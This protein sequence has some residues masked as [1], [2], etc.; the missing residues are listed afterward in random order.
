[1][2]EGI[3]E[4]N[5]GSLTIDAEGPARLLLAS[6]G[7]CSLPE[8][9]LAGLLYRP[10]E[11]KLRRIVDAVAALGLKSQDNLSMVLLDYG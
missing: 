9:D 1:M 8:G 6:D 2:G 4:I 10:D 5:T 3:P 7:I 11:S